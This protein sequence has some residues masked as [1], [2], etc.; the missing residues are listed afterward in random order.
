MSTSAPADPR[1]SLRRW[2]VC[3]LLMLAT[4]INYMDRLAMNQMALR[5]KTY[6]GMTNTQYSMLESAFSFAFAFGAFTTGLIVDKISVRWVYPI[7]V[8]GWSIA[9]VLTGFANG[10]WMLLTCRFALGLFE[11]GNW[12][13][14]IRTTRAVLRPDERSFGNAIF[15]SGT[16]LGAVI[17]PLL[18]LALLR[19]ADP[20]EPQRHAIMAVTGG[21]YAAVSGAPTDT[22]KYPFRVIG[23]L[24][25][26]WIVLWFTTVP[27]SMLHSP[28]GSEQEAQDGRIRFRDILRDPR[29]WVLLTTV[30]G[31]NVTW[32]GYR[33]WL[34][35]YLQEQRGF[36]ELEMSRFTTL[37]YLVADIGSWTAGGCALLLSRRGVGVHRSRVIAYGFCAMLTMVTLAVPFLPDGWPL[38]LALLV[39]AFGAL[40]LFPIYFALSQE[41]SVRHQGKVSGTLGAA[42]HIS[43]A[44]IYPVEGLINDATRSYEFVLGGI[45]VMPI[46][47]FLFLLW[48]W[49]G[50]SD[51]SSDPA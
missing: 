35:L 34:P 39:V 5:I 29:I 45:G 51:P 33:A 27:R 23:S 18:V 36:N 7:M 31:I 12:P 47:A 21:S 2:W 1:A 9:G 6:F 46:L 38:A 25:V 48:K 14:G 28:N 22:W 10:F 43:L 44:L 42:A 16:A 4:I 17:T 32:H 3:L 13:C 41:L 24:G 11:S 37:Y 30:I 20:L 19:S 49:P 40:G 15:Q 26:V 8:L 50:T